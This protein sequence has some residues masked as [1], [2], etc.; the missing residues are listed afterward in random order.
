MTYVSCVAPPLPLPSPP[1]SPRPQAIL[2]L[3]SWLPSFPHP[4]ILHSLIYILAKC[5]CSHK[6]KFFRSLKYLR[7]MAL[8][9]IASAK[10]VSFHFP[11]SSYSVIFLIIKRKIHSLL[12]AKIPHRVK[13]IGWWRCGW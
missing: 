8:G 9:K 13:R 1:P 10:F 12:K 11:L 7:W 5:K 6:I 3:A 4:Q 2:V